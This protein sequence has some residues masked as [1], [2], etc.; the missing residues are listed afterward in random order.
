[1]GRK[2]MSEAEEAILK[3]H[4]KE[5]RLWKIF[6]MMWVW[7][8]GSAGKPVH[9]LLPGGGLLTQLPQ[10]Q[11][12]LRGTT[13]YWNSFPLEN[14]IQSFFV[15]VHSKSYSSVSR[16]VKKHWGCGLLKVTQISVSKY[17]RSFY[18]GNCPSSSHL[19]VVS[20][21]TTDL[22][23]PFSVLST[24]DRIKHIFLSHSYRMCWFNLCV[25]WC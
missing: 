2:R 20:S 23:S 16:N 10:G 9:G 17:M 18:P 14:F 24:P 1:M 5:E 4:S 21:P 6:E 3:R 25:L 13:S 22:Q 15:L 11:R 19:N 12:Y 7:K 8:P